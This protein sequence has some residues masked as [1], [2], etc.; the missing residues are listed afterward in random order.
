MPQ[1]DA[2]NTTPT[3]L[4]TPLRSHNPTSTW[5]GI[6]ATGSGRFCV[7]EWDS[8]LLGRE[9]GVGGLGVKVEDFRKRRSAGSAAQGLVRA[10]DVDASSLRI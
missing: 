10:S 7:L 4:L 8:R 5:L 3:W 1:R 2:A 9:L 6:S